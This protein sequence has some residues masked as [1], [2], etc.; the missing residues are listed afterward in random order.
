[1][2]EITTLSRPYA[3]AAFLWAV[4]AKTLECWSLFL[5]YCSLAMQDERVRSLIQNPKIS[6]TE[7]VE[8]FASMAGEADEYAKNFLQTL[9]YYRKLNLLP[10]IHALF[11]ELKL[12][13]EQT[14][15]VQLVSAKPL[16]DEYQEK[17]EKVLS[18]YLKQK[19]LLQVNVDASLIGGALVRVGDQVI[20]GSVKGQLSRL[21]EN[22]G[23]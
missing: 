20:D 14:I 6:L 17:F 21:R 12:E 18:A 10:K 22:L 5:K 11:E 4:Q 8:F 9:A 16:N 19:V 2:A 3:K 7:K 23:K 15:A 1:M 13:H